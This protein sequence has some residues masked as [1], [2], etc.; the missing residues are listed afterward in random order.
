MN[1]NEL[2]K[3]EKMPTGW[4]KTTLGKALP[5]LYGKG[6]TKSQR[7]ESGP[8]PVYGSSGEIGQHSSA[9]TKTATLI[10]G[11]KGSVGEIHLSEKP[12][13]PIDTVYFVEESDN[14]YLKFFKYLLLGLKLGGLDKSTAIPGLSRDDYNSVQVAIAP[15]KEQKRIVAE[16]EK[17]FSRLDEAVEN[18]KRV[19][20]NLKRY[21]AAILK[22]AIE[23]KLTEKWRAENP[24]MEP[25]SELL[26]RILTERRKKWEEAELAKMKAEG[27]V[28]KDDKWK[29]KYRNPSTPDLED[30]PILPGG[31]I[32][33]L[34]EQL[35][36]IQLGKM[37]DRKKH[38]AGKNFPYLRNLNVRWG[39]I[40]TDDLKEM[41]FKTAELDRYGLKA[42]D[43]LVCEGGEPGRSAVWD[44]RV[45]EMK[46]QKALHRV[47]FYGGFENRFL[48]LILEFLSQNG[49]LEKL[50]TGS[51]IKHFTR[52]SF[53]GLPIPVPPISEQ[54]EILFLSDEHLSK[55]EILDRD[56]TIN[57]S[58]AE[59]LRQ[60]ILKKAFSGQ[61]VPQEIQ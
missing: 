21:K 41:V 13:W 33:A 36:E 23:G 22:A 26:E 47:R 11:R 16:I 9:I 1:N 31:W 35:A 44:G 18:L 39:T 24:N 15:L 3:I 25:A 42:G 29:K 52:E 14:N 59:S 49:R 17:Q 8:Y 58:R 30:L 38:S 32:W 51:T 4:R 7:D 55:I 28:P 34:T 53:V 61:L 27:K 46:Y 19:K 48:V 6:L 54:K 56:V 60:S 40:E 20:A 50:F 5:I 12:C 10:I 45:S 57:L 37:L 2:Q 43:V